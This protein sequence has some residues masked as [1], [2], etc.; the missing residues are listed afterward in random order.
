M[1][2]LAL[3]PD[4]TFSPSD[5]VPVGG[6]AL[7]LRQ[8]GTPAQVPLDFSPARVIPPWESAPPGTT[9]CNWK[10]THSMH[11]KMVW[12]TD[13]VPKYKSLQKLMDAALIPFIEAL[14]KEHHK[15]D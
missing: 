2:K 14:V 8:P 3:R 12:I 15:P 4:F 13:N 1:E 5:I 7:Q 9:I 10:H 11:A 6:G